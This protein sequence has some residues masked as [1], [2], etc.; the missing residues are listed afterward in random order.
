MIWQ[1][2]PWQLLSS[3]VNLLFYAIDSTTDCVGKVL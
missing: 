2:K 3:S 1:I